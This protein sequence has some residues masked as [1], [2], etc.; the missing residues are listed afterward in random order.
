MTRLVAALNRL[1]E[2]EFAPRVIPAVDVYFRGLAPT[3]SPPW[4]SRYEDMA[5]ALRDP[6]TSIELLRDHPGHYGLTRN[7]CNITRLSASDK[8]NVVPTEAWAELDCRLLP[9]Q[10]PDAFLGELGR[11]LGEHV[12]VE[13][14]M[15]FTPATSSSE[16]GLFRMIEEVTWSHFPNATVVPSVAAGFT[17]S[18]FLRDLEITAYG[19]SPFVIPLEDSRG[20]HG[21]DE[22]LSVENVKRGVRVM[23]DVVQGWAAE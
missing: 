23:L 7:T 15:G 3:M 6:R 8:I 16:T 18:H 20:V 17:D 10:D 12:G 11:V 4:R 9:G 21:N 19:Y 14:Q 22:R 2:H 1:R 13:T 5:T